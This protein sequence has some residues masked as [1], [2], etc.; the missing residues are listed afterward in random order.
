MYHVRAEDKQNILEQFVE[1]DISSFN[2]IG[3]DMLLD[4]GSICLEYGLPNNGQMRIYAKKPPEKGKINEGR[5]VS[6]EV[7]IRNDKT[8]GY[9]QN[10]F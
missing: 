10:S 2:Y 6:V 8:G 5:K 9:E 4:G 7:S 1:Y 3:V